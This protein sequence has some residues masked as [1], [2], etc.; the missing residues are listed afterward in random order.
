M[1]INFYIIY[2]IT[3]Y[4]YMTN[5]IPSN[6]KRELTMQQVYWTLRRFEEISHLIGI[7]AYF[8]FQEYTG[9]EP[10][11]F[12]KRNLPRLSFKE[13]RTFRSVTPQLIDQNRLW[14]RVLASMNLRFS[15]M[16]YQLCWWII[17]TFHMVKI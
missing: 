2:Y 3:R 10:L 12:K 13:R 8:I 6:R 17:N 14:I 9:R 5:Y 1:Y 7:E 16:K 11:I 4:R 15:P